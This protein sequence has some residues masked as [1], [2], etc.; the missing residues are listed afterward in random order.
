[1]EK[2]GR[3]TLLKCEIECESVWRNGYRPGR[4]IVNY[5]RIQILQAF[6]TEL[7]NEFYPDTD[8]KSRKFL[9]KENTGSLLHV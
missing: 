1:M 2:K 3:G 9:N 7:I 4:A 8:S 5:G 6:Y